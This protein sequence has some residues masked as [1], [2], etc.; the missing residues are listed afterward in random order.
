[1]AQFP[2]QSTTGDPIFRS[3][4]SSISQIQRLSRSAADASI[5][6]NS[7]ERIVSPGDDALSFSTSRRIRSEVKSLK[8]VQETGQLNITGL[9]LAV[10][11][12]E[13]IK[14]Q[15]D[16][17]KKLFVQSQVADT[18]E[19]DSIQAEIDL[20]LSQIDSAAHN[21]KLGSRSLLN[22]ESTINAYRTIA[23]T[24]AITD[25]Q[26]NQAQSLTQNAGIQGVTVNKIGT[27]G[28]T[29]LLNDGTN[30]L[31]LNVSILSTQKATRAAIVVSVNGNGNTGDFVELRV[32]GNLGTTTV[33]L[34]SNVTSFSQV[35][36]LASSFN[37]LARETGV[38]LT[39][40]TTAGRPVFTTVGYGSDEFIKIELI[41]SNDVAGDGGLVLRSANGV[42]QTS[43][44]SG[45][46]LTSFGQAATAK[47]N[48]FNVELGG[49][50]GTS[51]RFLQNGYD[52]EID[53]STLGLAD[54]AT[55]VS[56]TI[57]INLTQGVVG[58]LGASGDTRDTLHY[59]FGNFTTEALGRGNGQYTVTLQSGNGRT[60]GGIGATGI[61]GN[62]LGSGNSIINQNSIADLG[63]GGALS[64]DSG[65]LADAV[66]VIDNA[67]D[68]VITEQTRLGTIQ[69]N[70]ID[71]VNRAE[72]LVG[73]LT[74]ADADIIGVDA[75]TE[76]TNLVQSQLGVSTASSVLSQ[77]NAIQANVFSLLR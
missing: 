32:T 68:Q 17:V 37:R 40:Q 12:L 62:P 25:F 47:I 9:G 45:T 24:G 69:G 71:A 65:R 54:T 31:S 38:V 5:K 27:G 11:A 28:A 21:T 66:S 73:N 33:R 4:H 53:F 10:D 57:N 70:F 16:D 58:L 49:P 55:N 15:L 59:G 74:A 41:N 6:L 23:N 48:G 8:V 13:G 30:V 56:D 76:I 67:I 39:S 50:N 14:N 20:A 1:M 64:L 2:I 63:S 42:L 43:A 61:A 52:V 3:Q 26:I 7:Q 46:V 35:G 29:K 60:T 34:E 51:A 36:D 77:A 18:A 19:R 22:G 72:V 75:A 44:Q